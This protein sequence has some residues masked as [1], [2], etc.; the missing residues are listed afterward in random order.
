MEYV[1]GKS[2]KQIAPSDARQ[3]GAA[4]AGRAGARLRASR[5]CPRS[6]TC[7]AAACSTAT[8]SRTTSIQTEEQLKLID[9]GAVRRIDDEEPAIYGT[10]GYQAPE[11]AE[12]GPSVAS[13]LYTV[14]RTLAVLTFDFGYSGLQRLP[15]PARGAVLAGTSPSTGCC[16]GPR[17][18]TRTRFDSAERD[19][20]AADRRCCGRCSS[21]RRRTSRARRLRDVRPRSRGS[22]A[23]VRCA[24][25][26][27]ASWW[28]RP[29]PVPVAHSRRTPA[30]PAGCCATLA[31]RHRLAG[32]P[33]SQRPGIHCGWCAASPEATAWP[34][35]APWSWTVTGSERLAQRPMA[36]GGSSGTAA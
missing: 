9:L 3:R 33:L 4:A 10:V 11:I 25:A 31:D 1:G 21:Q 5:S 13:D 27:R 6:A 30:P 22:R 34:A 29:P 18:R 24:A 35:P 12:D 2:L 19:G 36:T 23:P 26:A 8:S 32:S 17:T 7:T 16:A 28:P 20:R 14:G 15:V